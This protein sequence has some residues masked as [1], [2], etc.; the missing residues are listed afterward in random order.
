MSLRKTDFTFSLFLL[1]YSL[2]LATQGLDFGDA[3]WQLTAYDNIIVFPQGIQYSF[4]YYLSVLLGHLWQIL[5][6]SGGL[7]WNRVGMVIFFMFVFLIYRILFKIYYPR[8]NWTRSL[9]LVFLFVYQGAPESLNYDVFTMFFNS[10][11]ILFLYLGLTERKHYFLFLSGIIAGL[12][13]F[14][15]IPNLAGV[16]FF[17]VIPFYAYMKNWNSRSLL[18]YFGLT[19]VGFITGV[20]AI[21]VVM[22][23]L[24]HQQYF[25]DNLT[26]LADMSASGDA[27][28][29]LSHLIIS[30]LK[31]YTKILIITGVTLIIVLF[32]RYLLRRNPHFLETRLYRI[33]LVFLM[34]IFGLAALEVGNPVWSKLRYL[35]F[36]LMFLNGMVLLLLRRVAV[37][38]RLLISLGL[39]LLIISPLGSDSGLDK[40][41]WG[42]WVLG[43]MLFLQLRRGHY[44]SIGSGKIRFKGNRELYKIFTLIFIIAV[45]T[46][47]WNNTY[48]DPGSR[49]AKRYPVNHPG[50]KGIY[51][52]KERAVIVNQLLS[53]IQPYVKKGDTLLAFIEMPMIHY[54]T[55]TRPYLNTSWPKLLYSP[56][57]F[58]KQLDLAE[59]KGALPIVV[60]QKLNMGATNWP[61]NSIPD[62]TEY[63]NPSIKY[64][65]HG[66]ELNEFLKRNNYEHVWGNTAFEILMPGRSFSNM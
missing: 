53:D 29:G 43:P 36:G 41:G 47:A 44:A 24:N 3:G 52:S 27:S 66:L 49:L 22:V 2:A 32:I 16:L 55:H 51:T 35:F 23:L 39:I 6:P 57:I 20:S 25:I 33:I 50:L 17:V 8:H 56:D 14:I 12:N 59:S 63:I 61:Y 34:I 42:S 54:L 30:Y 58:K 18:K 62:Y 45:L 64:R 10:L 38:T 5:L 65:E 7:Y 19:F 9:A 1:I 31:G 11:I 15:K 40:M 48:N 4:M 13:I 46:Y 28:H 37:K 21:I 26:F 60:R